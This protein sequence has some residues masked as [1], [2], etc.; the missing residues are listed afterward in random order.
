VLIPTDVSLL[1]CSGLVTRLLAGRL[2]QMPP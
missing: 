2:K 1:A